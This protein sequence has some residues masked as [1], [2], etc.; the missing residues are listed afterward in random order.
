[1][2]FSHEHLGCGRVC[3]CVYIYI[4]PIHV[5]LRERKH[6][7][8]GFTAATLEQL[9]E[10]FAAADLEMGQT[11]FAQKRSAV[12]DAVKQ[13]FQEE[14]RLFNSEMTARCVWGRAGRRVR[15]MG[16]ERVWGG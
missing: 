1:M 8:L 2:I 12:R 3:V 7:R 9:D 11:P 13:K 14:R 15:G 4:K 10:V 16:V 5:C 6:A